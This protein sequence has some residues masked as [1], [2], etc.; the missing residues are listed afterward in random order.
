MNCSGCGVELEPTEDQVN[1]AVDRVLESSLRDA[2]KSGGV[3]PL[4]GHCKDVPYSHRKSIQFG[5]LLACMLVASAV[6]F[7]FYKSRQT[8]R[9]AVANEILT[10]I[11]T[12]PEVIRLIGEPVTM[13][14]GLEGTIKQDETGW[15]ESR[16]TVPV[17]APNGEA[18]IHAVGG[19]GTGP[20]V[21]HYV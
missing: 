9:A 10:R 2:H 17:C 21:L 7:S 11:S 6:G 16:L 4:C 13:G 20:W 3:C 1:A 12:N 15:K 19:K 8:Q 18:T 14:Q 5:L